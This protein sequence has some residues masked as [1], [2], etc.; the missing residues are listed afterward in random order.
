MAPP[1]IQFAPDALPRSYSTAVDALGRVAG[2]AGAIAGGIGL[3]LNARET[4]SRW[5]A[6]SIIPFTLPYALKQ[7]S[8]A[9][10]DLSKVQRGVKAVYK[11]SAKSYLPGSWHTGRSS[12]TPRRYGM[13]LPIW[14]PSPPVRSR[15]QPRTYRRRRSFYRKPFF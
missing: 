11:P 1:L 12:Y 15:R 9:S 4:S 2:G 6:R 7:L 10:R 14:R 8:S 3:Y 5:G 13:R